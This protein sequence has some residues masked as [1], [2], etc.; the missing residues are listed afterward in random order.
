MNI[1]VHH[2]QTYWKLLELR[3]GTELKLTKLDDEIYTDFKE[4]FSEY[5]TA[6]Q[7]DEEGMKSKSGKAKWRDFMKTFED[8]VQDWNFGT[9]IRLN[10]KE[11]YEQ[12]TTIFGKQSITFIGFKGKLIGYS[13]TDAIPCH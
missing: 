4:K 11:E 12:D 7:I 2:A 6:A 8:K 1:A 13:I 5:A 10:A 9:L 3:K